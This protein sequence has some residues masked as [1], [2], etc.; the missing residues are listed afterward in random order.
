MFVGTCSNKFAGFCFEIVTDSD[1]DLDGVDYGS[2]EDDEE[3]LEDNSSADL[4]DDD[5]TASFDNE[6]FKM[7]YE[8]PFEHPYDD[9]HDDDKTRHQDRRHTNNAPPGV[10]NLP[11]YEWFGKQIRNGINKSD[12]DDN[13][14]SCNM[15][16]NFDGN[17]VERWLIDSGAMSHITNSDSYL[18]EQE[19]V[20]VNVM[21]GDGKEI[22]CVKRGNVCVKKG[23]Q[24]LQLRRVLLHLR[25]CL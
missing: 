22:L 3:T 25:K 10:R 6:E 13:K 1:D 9:Y 23:L 8:Q 14:E 17:S 18:T 12:D 5:T 21:V 7:V 24:T 11:F 16:T 4:D 2:K 20:S 19:S 15:A